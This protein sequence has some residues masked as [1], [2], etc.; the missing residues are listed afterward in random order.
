[1]RT[2][3]ARSANGTGMNCAVHPARVCE[4][5]PLESFRKL[6]ARGEARPAGLDF[7]LSI[8]WLAVNVSALGWRNELS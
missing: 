2:K 6:S 8:Q 3:R 1:M 5:R 4:A 7:P